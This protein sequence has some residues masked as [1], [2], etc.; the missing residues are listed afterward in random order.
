VFADDF[1]NPASGW[2]V[3][4]NEYAQAGYYY[5]EYRIRV[6]EPYW[7]QSVASPASPVSDFRLELDARQ[8]GATL[9]AYGVVFA[10]SELDDGQYEYYEF[11]I[12]EAYAC[13][14]KNVCD[15][16]FCDYTF[17]QD[18]TYVRLLRTPPMV[19]HILIQR[20]GSSIR[21]ELNGVHWQTFNDS[22]LAGGWV[23]IEAI[24]AD[25][26]PG[27]ARFDNFR[28]ERWNTTTATYEGEKPTSW[29]PGEPSHAV[30]LYALPR[31]RFG[32]ERISPPAVA[33]D[34]QIARSLPAFTVDLTIARNG[35]RNGKAAEYAW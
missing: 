31:P 17:I 14:G 10:L 35:K 28:L 33:P 26:T 13:L 27:D 9:T 18:M 21:I 6:Y 30:P 16:G 1:S 7:R 22:S 34:S 25:D 32:I 15:M 20:T 8:A 11:V 24:V 23:D 2:A 4:L 29:A 12:A 3:G 19:N 5:G